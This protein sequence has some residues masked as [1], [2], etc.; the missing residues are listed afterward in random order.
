MNRSPFEVK[1]DG[2]S[3]NTRGEAQAQQHL[4]EELLPAPNMVAETLTTAMALRIPA[5]F[6][7]VARRDLEQE[8]RQAAD[9]HYV[10]LNRDESSTNR[11]P[12]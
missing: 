3:P 5:R 11:V 12:A 4:G 6:L 8:L 7:H 9:I 2:K 1:L 10:L